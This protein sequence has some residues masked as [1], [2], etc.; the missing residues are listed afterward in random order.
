MNAA[1]Q[2]AATP[3]ASAEALK[4][5]STVLAAVAAQEPVA[6]IMRQAASLMLRGV[7]PRREQPEVSVVQVEFETSDYRLRIS[8]LTVK[9]VPR[10]SRYGIA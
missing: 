2:P 5:S 8:S 3:T 6:R 10:G 9:G 4:A 7:T 1:E